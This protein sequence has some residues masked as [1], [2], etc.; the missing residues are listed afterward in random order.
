MK[1]TG[2]P[3]FGVSNF[4]KFRS[5]EQKKEKELKEEDNEMS[6]DS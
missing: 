3:P 1:P 6:C 5:A 2:M 4:N